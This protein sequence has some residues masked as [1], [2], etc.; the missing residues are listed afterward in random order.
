MTH[1]LRSGKFCWKES[2]K[3]WCLPTSILST[4]ALTRLR[5]HGLFLPIPHIAVSSL[6]VVVGGVPVTPCPQDTLGEHL[7]WGGWQGLS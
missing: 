4:A 2:Q 1:R 6:M 5:G 7:L 3:A